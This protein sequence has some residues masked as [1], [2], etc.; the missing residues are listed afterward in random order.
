MV[1][2]EDT[3]VAGGTDLNEQSEVASG[4][5][6]RSKNVN[7]SPD[8]TVLGSLPFNME[9]NALLQGMLTKLTEN[10]VVPATVIVMER[11]VVGLKTFT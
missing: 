6:V 11:A 3:W 8:E 7:N 10:M 1:V 5:E 4:S 2:D 9:E